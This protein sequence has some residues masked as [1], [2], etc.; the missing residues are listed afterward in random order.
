M[1]II[2]LLISILMPSL[3]RARDQAKGV[4][5]LARLHD[6]GTALASYENISGDSLPPA[7]WRPDDEAQPELYYGW[8]EAL[9][10]HIYKETVYRLEMDDAPE[11]FPVQRNI[12]SERWAEY[13]ICKASSFRGVNSGNYRVYL[14][15]W[16]AGT[17][18]LNSD[19]TYDE[20]RG[21]DPAASITRSAVSPKMLLIGDANER[22]ERGDGDAGVALPDD[23]SY[24]DAG[25]ANVSG[26]DG[27]T[28]NRFSDRHCG[29][30][31]YLFQDLHGEWNTKLRQTLARDYDLNG[32]F[33]IEAAP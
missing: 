17:Y 33:D 20:C 26:S 27:M 9:F 13:F 6:I 21:A 31:N 23:C 29:G 16:A 2:S 7:E 5:C 15:S 14:P 10:T 1:A 25:E 32:I 3:G 22:S 30:T 12:D 24:I 18:S 4:H 19:G 28:G 8:T 11:C